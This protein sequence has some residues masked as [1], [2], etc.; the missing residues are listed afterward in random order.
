M[1]M[2]NFPL[3]LQEM[4]APAEEKPGPAEAAAPAKE[5]GEVAAPTPVQSG[6]SLSISKG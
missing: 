1:R 6:V 3:A 2:R 5:P 4:V